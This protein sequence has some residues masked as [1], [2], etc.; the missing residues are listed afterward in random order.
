MKKYRIKIS[1]EALYDIRDIALWYDTQKTGLGIRFQNAIIKQIE[2][3]AENPHIFAIRYKEIRCMV[4][5][6]FPYMIH[7]YLNPNTFT[8]EVL[9]VIGTNRNPIVWEEKTGRI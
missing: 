5:K 3:I 4:V 2:T 6:K 9:A 8:I 1:S 7:F